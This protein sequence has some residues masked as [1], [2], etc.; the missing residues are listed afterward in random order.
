MWLSKIPR[1]FGFVSMIAA[2]SSPIA[3][4]TASGWRRPSGPEAS[5]T[6]SYPLSAAEA[7]LVPWAVSGRSTLRRGFPFDSWYARITMSPQ[8]S[9]CAPAAGDR[10][11]ASRPAISESARSR[12]HMSSSAP[13]HSSAGASGWTFAKPG[14]RASASEDFG[15]YFIVQ[16]PSG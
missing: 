2:T 5:W 11:V 10:A 8:S 9:P 13:W 16:E 14:S 4:R 3:A 12:F 15:L 6:T 7:G 1:V